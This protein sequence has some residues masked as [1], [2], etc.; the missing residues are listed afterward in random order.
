MEAW[1]KDKDFQ[2]PPNDGDKRN[3][4]QVVFQPVDFGSSAPKCGVRVASETWTAETEYQLKVKAKADMR[5]ETQD[6][7]REAILYVAKGDTCR[8][9]IGRVMVRPARV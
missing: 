3:I 4:P 1:D 9:E 2:C 6:Q 8:M 7:E 5:D